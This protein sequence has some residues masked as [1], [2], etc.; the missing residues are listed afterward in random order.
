MNIGYP[1]KFNLI[2]PYKFKFENDGT[3]IKQR[4]IE[5]YQKY[6]FI[7][8]NILLIDSIVNPFVEQVYIYTSIYNAVRKYYDWKIIQTY[9]FPFYLK[10]KQKW[11]KINFI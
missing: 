4:I 5:M 11:N 7:N 8:L 3:I 1:V 2:E 6:L 9:N 10:P